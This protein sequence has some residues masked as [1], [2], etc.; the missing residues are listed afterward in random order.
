V[1][2]LTASAALDSL[3]GRPVPDRARG[4]RQSCPAAHH[5]VPQPPGRGRPPL[6]VWLAAAP[7]RP[8]VTVPQVPTEVADARS[9]QLLYDPWAHCHIRILRYLYSYGKR[10][11]I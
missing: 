2:P 1:R 6:L 10:F 4:A 5:G 3:G 7:G 11:M 9:R 8:R